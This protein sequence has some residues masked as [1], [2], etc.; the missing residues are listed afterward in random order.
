MQ[1][2]TK[3]DLQQAAKKYLDPDRFVLITLKPK[4]AKEL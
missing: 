2:V 1:E 3:D 4:E